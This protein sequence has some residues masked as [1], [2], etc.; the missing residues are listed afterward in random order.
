MT[1]DEPEAVLDA[2]VALRWGHDEPGSAAALALLD[3][4]T[5]WLAPRLLLTEIAAALVRKISAGQI[6]PSVSERAIGFFLD[7]VRVG[8]IR[9]AEDEAIVMAALRIAAEEKH[10]LPDCVYI[11]LAAQEG[12][13]LITADLRQASVAGRRGIAVELLETPSV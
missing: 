9:L 3:R 13:P 11:A 8:D 5:V 2:S 7:S 6:G 4:P 10:K 12:A 1:G